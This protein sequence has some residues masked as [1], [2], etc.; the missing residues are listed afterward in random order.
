SLM[1]R[2]LNPTTILLCLIVGLSFFS[3]AMNSTTILFAFLLVAGLVFVIAITS[4][5][6][7]PRRPLT[8]GQGTSPSGSSPHGSVVYP[9]SWQGGSN[10]RPRH[11]SPSR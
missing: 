3:L 5:P 10:P 2:I 8:T 4:E 11:Q 6:P 1:K 9:P 7:Q